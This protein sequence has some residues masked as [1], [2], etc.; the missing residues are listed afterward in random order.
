[1]ASSVL[2]RFA[3]LTCQSSN[4][5]QRDGRTALFAEYDT[6]VAELASCT[7]AHDV[8]SLRAII[9]NL[10]TK[11]FEAEEPLSFQSY[12]QETR[13]QLRSRWVGGGGGR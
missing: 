1:M 9:G 3:S 13:L 7:S 5:R 11:L 6:K 10:E 4:S 8:L 2:L 12:D